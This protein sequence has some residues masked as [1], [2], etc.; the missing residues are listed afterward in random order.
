M[1]RVDTDPIVGRLT[2]RFRVIPDGSG[3]VVEHLVE[4]WP[5]RI[6][7]PFTSRRSNPCEPR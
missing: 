5:N 7:L 4:L 3:A 1:F 6:V 2:H